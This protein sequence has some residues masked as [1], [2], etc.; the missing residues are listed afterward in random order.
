M[1]DPQILVYEFAGFELDPARRLL[2][3]TGGEPVPLA[4]KPFDA[5]VHLAQRAGTVVTR[6]ALAAALWPT[7]IVEDNNLSQTIAALRRA[8]GDSQDPPRFVATVPRRGYQ[9]V[10]T[11]RTRAAPSISVEPRTSVRAI[12]DEE[13]RAAGASPAPRPDVPGNPQRERRSGTLLVGLGGL[14]AA[15][16]I[17][18]A[19]ARA[20]DA[21]RRAGDDF[22]P[23][24]AATTDAPSADARAVLPRSV[25]VLPFRNLSP[26]DDDAYFAAGMHEE[27]LSRLAKVAGLNVI[28]STSVRRYA[29]STTP[30]GEIASE[31]N[32]ATVVEGTVRYAPDRIRVSV[33]LIDA[34]T[35]AGVWSEEYD[36]EPR[37]VFDVQ[38][39]VAAR[40]AAALEPAL[41]AQARTPAP[42]PTQSAQAYA[43]YLRTLSLYRTHGGI[44]V[45]MP[46]AIRRTMHE[47]LDD[48]LGLDAEFAAALA[49]RAHLNLDSLLF[50]PPPA[51]GWREHRAELAR[52]ID[53]DARRALALDSGEAAAYA[54]LARLDLFRFRLDDARATLDRA[55]AI[56]PNDLVVL[57]YSAMTAFLRDE[58]A[59]AIRAARR[60][61]E[62][63]PK[64]PAPHTPLAMA[65][66][67]SGN[68]AAAAAEYAAMIDAAPT[69][70]IGY[71]G[72]ARTRSAGG[73]AAA[74][75]E[76]LRLAEQFLD[77]T[78][79]FRVDAA[80]SYAS[81]G[82]RADAERLI[83]EFRRGVAGYHVDAGLEAM[84]LLALGEHDRA[85]DAIR[86]ALVD[87]GA[88]MD[89]LP[90]AL[91]RQN[92]WSDPTLEQPEWVA[93]RA[94][95]GPATVPGAG[96]SSER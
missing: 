37:G 45:S 10:A 43:L 19:I 81:A 96:S 46:V 6:Q 94:D 64:N 35:S 12:D 53:A 2:T 28:A 4:G 91:I 38:A 32:V 87:R 92:T 33:R 18:L 68:L 50:D 90:F 8:L 67:A 52:Q 79:N 63:D 73:D 34:R 88:G 69:A 54:T 75:L 78:L 7:T 65:L 30:I 21:G 70:A 47:Y 49:W 95:L 41:A 39:D 77:D 9:F 15:I 89:P 51:D 27:I 60:A 72:L 23:S 36:V 3:R 74:V 93:L 56:N 66:R 20:I 82:A 71:V 13:A 14:V 29:D 17:G 62:L 80:Y 40:I 26:G 58:H 48:A 25:A 61:L 5:L 86:A 22:A 59:A 16:A 76:P 44:G 57:H 85:R 55:L 84:A 1:N 31:L 11:V 24:R 83:A 42:P